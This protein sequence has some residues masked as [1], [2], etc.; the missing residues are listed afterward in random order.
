MT[1]PQRWKE[2][3]GIF[4][5][6]L[7][8]DSA[9]R[10]AFLAQACGGDQQLRTEVESLLAHVVPESFIGGPVVDEAT[11]LLVYENM[12]AP[13]ITSIGPYQVVKLLGPAG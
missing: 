2:I 5:A 13:D 9:E 4:E 12:R 7:E 6:A 11:Q 1:S 10:P 8:L 3:D